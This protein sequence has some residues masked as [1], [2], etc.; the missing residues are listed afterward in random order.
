MA[1][2]PTQKFI[3][4]FI[5]PQEK[6][7]QS[8]SSTKAKCQHKKLKKQ[9]LKLRLIKN[10]FTPTSPESMSF[11]KMMKKCT[12]SWNCV[13]TEN[14]LIISTIMDLFPKS[15]QQRFSDK[16]YQLLNTLSHREFSTVISSAKTLCLTETGMQNLW[17]SVLSQ[18]RKM[19]VSAALF[20]GHLLIQHPS[21]QEDRNTNLKKLMCGVWESVCT[22]WLLDNFL[23]MVQS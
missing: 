23:L 2:V 21:W 6:Q 14:F 19:V 22:L 16:F 15:S 11:N 17:I 4:Q 5:N 20:V 1:W 12:F 8:T 3:K 10:F 13:K 18:K 9:D 7:L